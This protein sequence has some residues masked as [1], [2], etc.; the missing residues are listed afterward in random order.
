MSSSMI[1]RYAIQDETTLK[2]GALKL[3]S[4]RTEPDRRAEPERKVIPMAR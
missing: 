1:W 2:E 4:F 3:L